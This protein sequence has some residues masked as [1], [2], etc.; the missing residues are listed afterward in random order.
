MQTLSQ[1]STLFNSYLLEN[2]FD[3]NPQALYT[4]IDYIMSLGG[5]RLRPAL[6][7]MSAN[8]F[9]ENVT[10]S[11]PASFAI[12]VFHNFSLVHDDIMDEAPLRRGQ[13]TVHHKYGI[14]TGIL[15]GDVMLIYAY[16][17]LIKEDLGSN[18]KQVIEI[19]NQVATE[20]CEGQQMDMDFERR[21]DV[22]IQEY[23]QMIEFKT[24]VLLA[25]AMQIGALIG[26]GSQEDAKHLYAFGRDIGIAFQLQDDILDTYGD[27]E[28]FGKKVGGDIAQNKKTFLVLKA[29]ELSDTLPAT[30]L[31]NWLSTP[32]SDEAT[33]IRAVMD[34]F[35]L[36][37]V[38]K[39]SE[40]LMEEY[41]KSA[42]AHL[43]AVSVPDA[44]KEILR[45]IANELMM[46][47]S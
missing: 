34:I 19:F 40:T 6:L 8:L 45:A 21:E 26:G 10:K 36:C 25:G 43:D 47:E 27:P 13:P 32:S 15:S 3:R 41:C 22:T 29:L 30:A 16:Q 33:K 5:K 31:R 14:N 38:R 35:D 44:Q 46:R 17:Y 28:K 2:Q 20:V 23:L 42:F 18:L 12:E 11:L 7:M 37:N 24:A 9:T 39:H 4:P 1:I